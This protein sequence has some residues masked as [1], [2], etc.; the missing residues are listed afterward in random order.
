MWLPNHVNLHFHDC[1]V[2]IGWERGVEGLDSLTFQYHYRPTPTGGNQCSRRKS[3]VSV[4]LSH[5]WNTTF[6]EKRLWDTPPAFMQLIR[7]L[8]MFWRWMPASLADS[9]GE[10]GQSTTSSCSAEP[11]VEKKHPV[12]FHLENSNDYTFLIYQGWAS[13]QKLIRQ[14]NILGLNYEKSFGLSFFSSD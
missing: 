11:E 10:M 12:C 1:N 9:L 3:M 5:S 6:S 13:F 2:V 8:D 7:E 4:Y 14:T